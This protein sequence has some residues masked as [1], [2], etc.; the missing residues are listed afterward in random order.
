MLIFNHILNKFTK[1]KDELINYKLCIALNVI[2][3][4]WWWYYY[5]QFNIDQSQMMTFLLYINIHVEW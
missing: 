1:S 2:Y 3:A 4:E 5:I